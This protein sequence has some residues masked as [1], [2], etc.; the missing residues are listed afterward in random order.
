MKNY[1]IITSMKYHLIVFGCQMNVSDSERLSAVLESMGYE[2]GKGIPGADL[3]VMVM[4]S[5]RQSAVD[6]IFGLAEKFKTMKNRPKTILTGCILKKD[7]K[8]F[9]EL[10]DHVL[11]I[12]EL[13][14][15]ERTNKFF[16]G[17]GTREH[18]LSRRKNLICE[19]DMSKKSLLPSDKR[20]YLP[21]SNGCNNFCTYCV[22][23]YTRGKLTC[24][25][26]KKII[27]EAEGLIKNGARE[28]WL[29]GQNV[30]DYSSPTDPSVNFARLLQMVNNLEGNFKIFFMSPNPKNFSDKLIKVMA[31][32]KKFSKYLNLPIQSGDNEILR[33]M[34]RPYTAEQYIALVK[35]IRKAIPDIN[36]STDVIVGFPG[37]TKKQFENTVKLF[38]KVN[39]N[40]AYINKYSPRWQT[41]AWKMKD[42]VP[43]KEKKLREKILQ[44]IIND[45]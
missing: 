10:F 45:K 4:C 39:F 13:L 42:D 3:V 16:R 7:R 12:S 18:G 37:E 17:E 44:D 25:D 11:P 9:S 15:V 22:V 26:H 43:F 20:A 6:R 14:N 30:N 21:I 19:R 5:V 28:I 27:K 1:C 34:N 36:L 41:A 29:L 31:Q 38:K 35:K 40:I 24:R 33:K 2:K 23:P 8:T 32:S